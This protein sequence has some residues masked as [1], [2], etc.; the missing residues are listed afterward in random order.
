MIFKF[1]GLF[2][3]GYVFFFNLLVW[4]LKR[5]R[6]KAWSWMGGDVGEDLGGND[7]GETMIG[8]FFISFNNTKRTM[9]SLIASHL[10]E[11][12]LLVM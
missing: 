1:W 7:G 5:E 10:T 2:C 12:C 11:T 6:N 9:D 8:I 4:F 3:F